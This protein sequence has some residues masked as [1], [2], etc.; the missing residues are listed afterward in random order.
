[1]SDFFAAR[2]EGYEEHM[3]AGGAE[4][5]YQK[6]ADLVP[7]NAKTILD[8]GCGTGLELD[9]IF[10][11]LPHVSV[12]GID[13]TQSMLD[14]LKAKHPENNLQLICGSY[15]DTEFGENVFDAAVSFATLHHFG[16]AEKVG[17][18]TRILKALKPDGVYIECDYM[19]TDQSIENKLQ[20]E[21]ATL[22]QAA[23]IPPGEFYHFDIPYTIDHQIEM[24]RQAGFASAEMVHRRQNSTIIIT[25][26]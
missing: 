15:F 14:R 2:L 25:R 3:L 18:Y 12:V 8:L 6:M 13:L 24:F 16:R 9:R 7:G 10:R 1:M 22:R 11:R 5:D 19:L 4:T 23:N 17:L 26:R 20:A 21:N